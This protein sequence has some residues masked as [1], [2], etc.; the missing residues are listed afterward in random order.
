MSATS[1]TPA[2][3]EPVPVPEQYLDLLNAPLT[4]ILTTI[5]ADGGPQAAPV[6]FTF[7]GQSVLVSTRANTQKQRNVMRNSRGSLTVIDPTNT[8][9]YVEL[10]GDVEVSDDPTFA[11]RERVVHK[12]GFAD[13]SSFDAP[14]VLRVTLRLTPTRII[15]H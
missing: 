4:G 9:R 1:A 14:G 10:R 2:T 15:E 7:D 6:W 13:G 5:G 8:M 3:N 12:H 11:T